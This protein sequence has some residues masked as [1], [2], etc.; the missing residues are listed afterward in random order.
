MKPLLSLSLFPLP[1]SIAAQSGA[2]TILSFNI[3][4][5]PSSLDPNVP[6]NKTENIQLIGQRLASHDYDVIHVQEDFDYNEA[7]YEADSHPHRTEP[8]GR[9][10]FG[11]G[12]NTLS[13]FPWVGFERVTWD[14]CA[15]SD[16]DGG[17][18]CLTP[19]GF[20]VMRVR[21]G[22]GVYVD[23]YNLHADAG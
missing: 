7:L 3:A 23:F 11:S 12:L 15:S 17:M 1:A 2:F 18:D 22:E 13:N 21:L 5:I 9:V 6:G 20:T 14:A 19:K 8:S 10:P 16:G 4:G